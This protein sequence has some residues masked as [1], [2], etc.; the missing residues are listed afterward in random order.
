VIEIMSV[1]ES[2][3]GVKY[4]TSGGDS[5]L[6]VDKSSLNRL[7]ALD[8]PTNLKAGATKEDLMKAMKDHILAEGV[9]MGIYARE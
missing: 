7:Y 6:V 1:D 3:Y 4:I 5:V 2:S 8:G 9:L